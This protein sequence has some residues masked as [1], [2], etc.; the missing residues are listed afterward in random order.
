MN[1][2]FIQ[3]KKYIDLITCLT[4]SH[5]NKFSFNMS[6][7]VKFALHIFSSRERIYKSYTYTN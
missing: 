2:H 7:H 4:R 6:I 3:R 5:K 1:D